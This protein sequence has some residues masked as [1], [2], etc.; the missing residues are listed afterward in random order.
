[1]MTGERIGAEKA[2]E[3]GLVNKVVPDDELMYSAMELAHQIVQHAP[4]ALGVIKYMTNKALAFEEHYDL[5]R[6]LAGHL[7]TTEDT[8]ASREAWVSPEP[9]PLSSIAKR[10][11]VPVVQ[12]RYVQRRLRL[13]SRLTSLL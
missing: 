4:L 11:G 6:A 1:M 3:W 13:L 7:G 8:R 12:P 10:P 9:F 2:L 5:E